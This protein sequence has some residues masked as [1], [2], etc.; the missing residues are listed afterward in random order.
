MELGRKGRRSGAWEG[1]WARNQILRGNLS[2][3][4]SDRL[5]FLLIFDFWDSW[6][7]GAEK[8]EWGALN[9]RQLCR[10]IFAN[11]LPIFFRDCLALRKHKEGTHV[12]GGASLA[13]IQL[14]HHTWATESIPRQDGAKAPQ[15]LA[16]RSRSQAARTFNPLSWPKLTTL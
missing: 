2:L 6:A 9:H 14:R 16:A 11:L 1:L 13:S 10:Q 7:R 5:R 12:E 3:S 8:G 15:A 4:D